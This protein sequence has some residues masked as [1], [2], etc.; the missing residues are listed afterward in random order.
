MNMIHPGPRAPDRMQARPA[1]LRPV[2]GRLR[3]GQTVMQA[4]GALFADHGCKG[5]VV[6]LAGL[7]C[8]PMRYVLPALSTDGLHAAWY[9]DTHAPEGR[10]TV[11]SATA[12]VGWKD[13]APFLHCHGIWSDGR[14]R[15][16]G[17]LLPFDS[18]VAEDVA[19]EGLGAA[20]TWFEALPDQETAFT[21]FTPQGGGDGPGLFARILPG[22]DVVAA[23]ETLAARHGIR[24][25][26][27]HAVG[28]IDHIR[29][30]EGHRMD[31]LATELRFADARLARG[32]AHVPIEVVDI[33]GH[34]ARGT[35]A[36]GANPVGVTLE[37]IIEPTGE[38]P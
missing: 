31:C 34:I 15:A 17:H 10:W 33:H 14:D 29:F 27:L 30:A 9:S 11:D 37:L 18:T 28:S 23:I 8:E 16:M 1:L 22:E 19:V 35:L 2:A 5:G 36:R 32:T 26:R 7:R 4:V 3:A 24:D 20:E 21:L 38:T 6:S 12:T 25:A 13:G